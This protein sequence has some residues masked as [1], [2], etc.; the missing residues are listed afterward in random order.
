MIR[1]IQPGFY[2]IKVFEEF[3]GLLGSGFHLSHSRFK[4]FHNFALKSKNSEQILNT[5]QQKKML[6]LLYKSRYINDSN[7]QRKISH[8]DLLEKDGLQLQIPGNPK[9]S[10][11]PN[12]SLPPLI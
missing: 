10:Q 8:L 4:E 7:Q 6:N 5:L 9:P 3:V 2:E 11:G 12:I 1:K